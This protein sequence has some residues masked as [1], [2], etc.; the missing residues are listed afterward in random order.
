MD[1]SCQKWKKKM[2]GHRIVSEIRFP[3]DPRK[4]LKIGVVSSNGNSVCWATR[5][6]NATA[7]SPIFVWNIFSARAL[8]AWLWAWRCDMNYVLSKVA[9]KQLARTSLILLNNFSVQILTSITWIH[10]TVLLTA[11]AVMW[12]DHISVHANLDLLVMEKHAKV[13]WVLTSQNY[14]WIKAYGK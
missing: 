7:T 1:Y 5:E 9:Q 4:I 12:W 10:M 13:S 6:V 11:V 8:D 14:L 2:G 3:K